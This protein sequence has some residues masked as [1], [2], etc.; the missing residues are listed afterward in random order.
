MVRHAFAMVQKVGGEIMHFTNGKAPGASNT[1]GLETDTNNVLDFASGQLQRK[2]IVTQIAKLASAGHAVHELRC[3][4]FL[5]CQYGYSDY[6]Q[7]F[8]A[9]QAFAR[10]LGVSK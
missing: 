2:A 7:D 4:D 1:E 8:D 5:V 10:R 6:A 9:L 3:G